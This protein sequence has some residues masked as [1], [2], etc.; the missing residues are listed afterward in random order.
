MIWDALIS[1]W[2]HCRDKEIIYTIGILSAD[3]LSYLM[4]SGEQNCYSN[5]CADWNRCRFIAGPSHDFYTRSGKMFLII[6]W[7]WL[8]AQYICSEIDKCDRIYQSMMTSWNRNI[9]HVPGPSCGELVI[10]E[11]LSQRRVTRSFDVFLDLRLKKRL[12]KQSRRWG[13]ET[14][15]H[16]LWRHCN[17][18]VLNALNCPKALMS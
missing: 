17:C 5:K 15:S 3:S 14:P 7:W 1:L 4:T 18:S 16:P 11:F 10:G 9:F 6:D 8:H 12:S 13:F 2:R